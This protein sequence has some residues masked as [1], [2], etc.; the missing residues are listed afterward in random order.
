LSFVRHRPQSDSHWLF[1][2]EQSGDCSRQPIYA[3]AAK[4]SRT[5]VRDDAAQL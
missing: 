1:N 3:V 2:P 5:S 4:H